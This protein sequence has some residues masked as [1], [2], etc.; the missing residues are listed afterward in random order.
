MSHTDDG[1]VTEHGRKAFECAN[2]T[3]SAN[4]GKKVW[5]IDLG[6]DHVVTEI[7]IQRRVYGNVNNGVL[8]KQVDN[9][10]ALISG[11][12]LLIGISYLW[13]DTIVF[14]GLWIIPLNI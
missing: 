8:F 11:Q 14:T 3:C 4:G 5:S 10:I 9:C 6:K 1:D 12:A 7:R 13:Q 2:T